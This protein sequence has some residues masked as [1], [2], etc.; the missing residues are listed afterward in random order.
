MTLF[1]PEQLQ[2]IVDAQQLD[3][4]G[5]SHAIVGTVNTEGVQVVAAMTFHGQKAMWEVQAVAEHSWD[6]DNSGQARVIV[7]W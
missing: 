3:P 2:K 7:Q 1:G 6:G 5:G 4:R